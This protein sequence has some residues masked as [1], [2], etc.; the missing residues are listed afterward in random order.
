MIATQFALSAREMHLRVKPLIGYR[1]ITALDLKDDF[2]R[3]RAMWADQI[4]AAV[5]PNEE[6]GRAISM[7]GEATLPLSHT[8]INNS[9]K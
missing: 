8:S 5:H 7:G 2:T 9:L 3:T 1:A 4:A 6:L